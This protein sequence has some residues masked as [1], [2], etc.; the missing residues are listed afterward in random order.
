MKDQLTISPKH[1]CA[2][3]L[4]LTS[5]LALTGIGTASAT[6]APQTDNH[7]VIRKFSLTA[8]AVLPVTPPA[9][10]A[11]PVPEAAP[12]GSSKPLTQAQLMGL[13]AG[14]V[15]SKRVALLIAQRGI[16]FQPT[17]EFLTDLKTS[18]ASDELLSALRAARSSP[19]S[20]SKEDPHSVPAAPDLNAPPG[21]LS[22]LRQ[23]EQEDRAAEVA[24]PQDASVHYA[25]GGV[26][27]QE[28]NWSEAAAQ[29]AA[30]TASEP[31][32]AAAHNNLA[33]ALRKSGDVDGAIRE[34]RRALAIYPAFAAVHD[35]LGVALSQ[36]GDVTGALAEFREAIREDPGNA[37]AHN[38]LGT[39]LLQQKD[40]DGAIREYRQALSLGG[41]GDVQ[42]NLAAALELKGDLDG[43]IAGFRQAV[44]IRP[45]DARTRT[46][47]GGAL[48]R[49]GDLSGALEQYSIALKLAPQDPTVRANYERLAKASPAQGHGGSCG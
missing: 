6:P 4:I 29:Y 1:F 25:L 11:F 49:K 48:E 26:L 2:A 16:A 39:M 14:G 20:Q 42:Y 40:D 43:A 8:L 27:A 37:Q 34:Y 23:T 19:A 33:L 45:N 47:L 10:V 13:V 15:A 17:P 41:G 24:R 12:D 22:H 44:T 18:G 30:V 35:N 28:G 21:Q 38:N 32:D 31:S 9:A 36:K 46:G 3:L 7:D 5:V